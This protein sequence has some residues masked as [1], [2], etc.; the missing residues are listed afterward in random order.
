MTVNVPEA[1]AEAKHI[2]TDKYDPTAELSRF[3]FP[4]ID[5]LAKREQRTDHVDLAEQEENKDRL[6]KTLST[7]GVKIS[8]IEATV[9]PTITRYE[10]IPAEGE[11]IRSIKNLGD[12]L[13]LSL[14]ALGI[15]IIAPI[16]GKGTIG[17]EVPNKD[18]QIVS[19]RG[20]PESS[21]VSESI[22]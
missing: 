13:A 22:M 10:V 2:Q 8:H 4:S 14:S 5:L 19:M 21:P 9:G 3:R 1:A 12:D 16:P 7:Y 20:I 6:T 17:I 11:R 18:P 15:R